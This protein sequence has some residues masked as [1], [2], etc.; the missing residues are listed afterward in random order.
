MIMNNAGRSKT[1]VSEGGSD[2][3]GLCIMLYIAA[4][5]GMN[6]EKGMEKTLTSKEAP[7]CN[8]M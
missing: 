8:G 3:D 1:Y 4:W 2:V 6:L 7:R 5:N